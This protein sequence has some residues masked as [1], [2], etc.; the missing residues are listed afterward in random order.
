MS[1]IHELK[2]LFK[3][4]VM[5]RGLRSRRVLTGLGLVCLLPL[6]AQV[7]AEDVSVDIPAQSL[8]QALQ[9]FGQQTNQQVIYNAGDMAGL[10][11]NRVSG[12]MSPQ[13]ALAELLKGT[14]VRYSVEG[15]TLMLLRGSATGSLELGATTVKAQELA[16]TTEGSKSYTSNAVTIGKGTH[17]LKE[18]P[19]SVTVMT[20][21]QMDDQNLVNLK[22]AVNQTTGIVGL[23]GVGQGMILSSRGFQIDD[24]QYDGVPIPRNTYSLG[25]WAT[26][27]L[28][29]FDRLEIMR[30]ASG[31]LQGTGSPGGAVNLVRKRGQ[32]APTVTLTGKAGSWDHYGLQLDA[33]GPLNQA[34]NIR[35]RIVVD[36]DQSNSFVDHAWSK[37][38]SLYGALDVDLSEDTT[39]GFAVSQSNGESRGNIRGLPRY[40]DG[41]MPDVSRS[42]YTGARWNRSE[43]DV[44][45]LYAD[46]EH[47]F[48]EDWAFKVGAVHMSEDNQ[49]KNQRVQRGGGL[50]P[51][52]SGVQYADFLTDFQSTKVGLDMNLTG[53]FEALSMAQEV[54]LGGNYSQLETDDRYARTF[55]N[56]SDSIFDID[57]DRP[58]I[59]YDSLIAAGGLGVLSKYD[60]RQKGVYGT[61]RV[62]PVDDLTL[63]LG[64]RVSWYDY[65]YKAKNET[66]AGITPY[67]G[68]TGT[69]TGVVTPYAGIIYDLSR[70][71]AVY[72]SYTDVFQPQ[73]NRD[74]N[75]SVLKPIVGTNYEVGLKGE[76]MD[77]RV[78]T[79]LAIF[80]YDHENRAINDGGSGCGGSGCSVASGKVRSQGIDA[81]ISGEVI[82]NLQLFAGYTYNTTKYLEDPDNE[83]S[84]FSTWTPKHMLRV[85]G[86]YQFTGDWS[87]VSTGL[88]FTTQSHTMVYDYD[89]EIPGY[90]VW[91]ARVGYQL[92][93]EIALAVNANNLFDKTYITSA[94]NQINGN[95]NFGDPRN[96]MF[97]VTYKPQF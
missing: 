20:R 94:Y 51:D 33:G 7:M 15:N 24:W 96:L 34:G 83:G 69:E 62:K 43:I 6:S 68:T 81:E 16:A 2:P 44:T 55:N 57:N 49:A 30:G 66:S 54:M 72:A 90:T 60:I 85:W 8:P 82:D 53:K 39:L 91:N 21:K 61:W 5:S 12:K 38:H 47:R 80:R 50:L 14:G 95:N 46:L 64:S 59:S 42:T 71:W 18:I 29:F 1:S 74:A 67:S 63:V 75:G 17:T 10:K 22:D 88:G 45:T 89:R 28:I 11:S 84:I 73:T 41:R 32:N 3:A 13:A 97:S 9:A 58:D 78:N 77:G 35:G 19:Q 40:A 48:N 86:N 79:S 70:E 36:E 23:Q 27:D 65:S 56:T 92:T 87:R 4:L 93:P 31:L 26:Q 25:N 76:L 52:G 37:T